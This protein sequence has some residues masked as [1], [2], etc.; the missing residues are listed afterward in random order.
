MLNFYWNTI[1]Y[2]GGSVRYNFIYEFTAYGIYCMYVLM[3]VYM[4]IK[5]TF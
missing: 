4:S 1:Q 2:D 5:L 3:Y